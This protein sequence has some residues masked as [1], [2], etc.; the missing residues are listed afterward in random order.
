MSKDQLLKDPRVNDP[1]IDRRSGEERRQAYDL[2]YFGKNGLER[3]KK[4]DRR[5]SA[6]RRDGCIR[7]T[8]WSS[9]CPD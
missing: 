7:V 1:Y 6:E 5:Q 2:D 4:D 3:R 8:D 9:V